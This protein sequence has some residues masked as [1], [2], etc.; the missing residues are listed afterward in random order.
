M[1]PWDAPAGKAP[2]ESVEIVEL[3]PSRLHE[4]VADEHPNQQLHYP[5][6]LV[7]Q[8]NSLF[9]SPSYQQQPAHFTG[10]SCSFHGKPL[11]FDFVA[12]NAITTR[13]VLVRS[14]FLEPDVR[15]AVGSLRR[16]A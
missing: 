3:A 8:M 9:N 1:R 4:E 5:F 13:N 14:G 7:K 10:T 11:A 2:R 15:D 16:W 6:L 12:K